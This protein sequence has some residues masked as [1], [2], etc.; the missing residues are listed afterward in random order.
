MLQL[1][2]LIK[3]GGVDRTGA[4]ADPGPG[5]SEPAG[6]HPASLAGPI[7]PIGP[8]APTGPVDPVDP[9]VPVGR[10]GAA[11]SPPDDRS[12][13]GMSTVEYA[14][15]TVAA[16]AFAAVL[17]QIV[18]GGSVLAGLTELINRAMSLF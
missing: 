2:S 13:A 15:G 14:V 17:Y 9:A 6:R 10:S 8:A 18:T 5:P 11:G 4:G 16:A 7:G 3:Q 12:D 1:V